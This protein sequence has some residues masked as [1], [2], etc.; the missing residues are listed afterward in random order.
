MQEQSWWTSDSQQSQC[1]PTT[2]EWTSYQHHQQP[3]ENPHRAGTSLGTNPSP[4]LAPQRTCCRTAASILEG[5]WWVVP[6]TVVRPVPSFWGGAC[7][8]SLASHSLSH[9]SLQIDWFSSGLASCTQPI[10]IAKFLCPAPREG[11]VVGKRG[12]A[13][14]SRSLQVVGAMGFNQS[15]HKYWFQYYWNK[16]YEG[17]GH[18]PCF[19]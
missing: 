13:L 11:P 16:S 10:S 14:L 2:L 9:S 7:D 8:P 5:V 15:L 4:P 6:N 12:S 3:S 17:K 19:Y 1:L 18:S